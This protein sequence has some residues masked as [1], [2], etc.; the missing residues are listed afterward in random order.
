MVKILK[1]NRKLSLFIVV[2]LLVAYWFC[3]PNPLFD[4]SYS[5]V[6]ADRNGELLGARI[7]DDGQWRFP[8]KD[9]IPAKYVTALLTF[10][11][12]RF[13]YHPGVDI[14]SLGRALLQNIRNGKIVSGGSTL[15]MQIIR[16]A[17]D[18]RRTLWQKM[19]EIIL[20]TRLELKYDKQ[21][22]LALYA[23]HAPFGGNVVGLEAA[24]W[25]YF[26]KQPG[27]LSWAEAATLAVLP[28]SPG[29]IHPGRNR[30]ALM[31]KRNRLL[32]K[33]LDNELLDSL[34]WEL[35]KA[36]PLPNE[37]YA[38]PRHAP[39]LLDQIYLARND[40]GKNSVKS[41]LD[42]S[43]Q[44]RANQILKRH[45]EILKYN[46]IYNL[47]AIIVEVETGHV[48]AYLGNVISDGKGNGEQVDIVKSVRSTGSILK[49]LLYAGMLDEGE[50]LPNSLVPD[51][52]SNMGGYRPE[53]YHE[54]YDGVVS[55][56]KALVRSLNVPFVRMLQN[57]GLEKFHFYLQQLGLKSIA[58]PAEYYGLPLVLGGAECSLWEITNAYTFL[59]R[60]LR[61]F[62][63]QSGEY[64]LADQKTIT[65]ESRDLNEEAVL[66]K[67][68]P[69]I[70]A[71]AIW[72]T[73]EAMKRVERP[74][75]QGNWERFSSS[76][77]IAWKTGTS[78]GF[79]DAWAIGLTKDYAVG[80]WAGNADGEGRPG[81][82]G[83]K[84]AAPVLFDLFD[85]LPA[86]DWFDP[87]F[88]EMVNL[89]VCKN[90]GYRALNICPVDTTWVPRQGLNAPVCPYHKVLHLDTTGNWQVNAD[91]EKMEAIVHQP[92]FV[93]PPLESFYYQVNHPNY[94]QPPPFR[95]DCEADHSDG[96]QAMQLIYPKYPTQIYIPVDIDGQFSRTVFS[97][98]HRNPNT[99]IF[100]HLDNEFLTTTKTFHTVEL[101]PTTGHHRLTLVD[102]AGN[103]LEQVF[104]IIAK[105][106]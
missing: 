92:W 66:V 27:Q 101:K 45:H 18:R 69:L 78:F 106:E 34:T 59:A 46:E 95:P 90:S 99:S 52:P 57:H 4:T 62:Y 86:S 61:N 102:E 26:A 60:T 6:L 47:A 5:T 8:P 9:S 79:R 77:N 22:I 16:M 74:N 37:V 11:D 40:L 3:L 23:A 73:F 55:A 105:E 35:S 70:S 100:W 14:I 32:D 17:R 98:A 91:C 19:I 67:E 68:A 89:P 12:K 63:P 31:A 1:Q 10:E 7:A 25:R 71:S 56:Q 75:E 80:V 65:I 54:K 2:L 21:E 64:N 42:L 84:A 15:S 33:L 36:E 76:Q 39:H 58:K 94:E 13:Y 97:V 93:L 96:Q 48:L 87:P 85:L 49:P 82:I 28:N 83:V 53:N 30:S 103:R 50:M 29:L 43:L 88:D 104:E 20:A 41:T 72:H 44:L 51:I 24:C 81:L 38:L